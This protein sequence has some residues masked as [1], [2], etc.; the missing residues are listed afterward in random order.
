MSQSSCPLVSVVITTLK[1][2]HLISIAI[3]SVLS[4]TLKELELIVVVDG[5]DDPLT[6]EILERVK[7]PRFRFVVLPV[8]MKTGMARNEGVRA[9]Q[10]PWVAFLDDDDT[11]MPEKLERQLPIANQSDYAYPI[12]SSRLIAETSRGEFIWPRRLPRV[13]EAI[14]DYLFVR[15]SMFQGEGMLLTST[16]LVPRELL[17]RVPFDSIV[18][19]DYDWLLRVGVLDG[20]GMEFVPEP[21]VVWHFHQGVGQP[22]LSQINHWKKTLAWIQS[23]EFLM[24][25]QAYA[26]FV[27]TCV[28]PPAAAVRDW[29][30]F[31]PL[32]KEFTM[33]GKAQPLDYVFFLVVWLIPKDLRHRIRQ[34]LTRQKTERSVAVN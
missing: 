25:P 19:E 13:D 12:V 34:R 24:S 18:H 17:E 23:I 9:A 28:S 31:W 30:A 21:M 8:N 6:V 4:Q 26:A 7:D 3:E 33:V 14:D 2:S 32:L 10:A 15:H 29:R 1:R 16:W 27:V 11:W 22:R 5:P 20:V